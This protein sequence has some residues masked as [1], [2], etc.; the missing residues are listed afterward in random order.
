MGNAYKAQAA[1]FNSG[2][3][4]MEKRKAEWLELFAEDAV[5]CDPVGESPLDPTGNGHKGKAAISA[6]WDMV[7]APGLITFDIQSSHPAGDECANVVKLT[8]TMPGGVVIETMM[9]ALY[10]ANDAGKLMSLRAYWD[11]S[12]VQEQ[13]EAALGQAG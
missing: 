4:V 13:L 9:V 3:F 1:S 6:F 5:V 10:R 2:K 12:K 7:I 8:N 11:Y